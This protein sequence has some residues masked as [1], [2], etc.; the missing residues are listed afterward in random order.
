MCSSDLLILTPLVSTLFNKLGML[1]P[2][3]ACK[4]F[5]EGANGFARAES[6]AAIYLTRASIAKRVYASVLHVKTNTDGYKLEGITYP[7]AAM[8]EQLLASV[9]AEADLSPA[10]VTY[11][12][13]HGT[14][15]VAGDP[16]ELLA[17]SKTFV[18]AQP[19]GRSAAPLLV[20]D[21]KSV[22]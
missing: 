4:S 12:E 20:G 17:L 18:G 6:V 16:T 11:V 13:A 10:E 15:T 2:D 7:S 9:Y 21:R 22:V 14:G 8:Q 1:S 19:H 3:S 5:D